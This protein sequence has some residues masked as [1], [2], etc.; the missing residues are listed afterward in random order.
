MVIARRGKVK[1]NKRSQ[2]A[3]SKLE[4]R[5]AK[6]ETFLTVTNELSSNYNVCGRSNPFKNM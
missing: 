2:D 6:R 3:N 5:N 4:T 1:L